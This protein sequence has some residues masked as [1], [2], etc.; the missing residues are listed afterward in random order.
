MTLTY[1]KLTYNLDI[2]GQHMRK[3]IKYYKKVN[4]GFSMVVQH[5]IQKN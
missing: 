1:N 2:Q 4:K 5:Y 3:G